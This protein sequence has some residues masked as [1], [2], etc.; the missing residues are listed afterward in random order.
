MMKPRIFAG[1]AHFEMYIYTCNGDE[2]VYGFH[3][4]AAYSLSK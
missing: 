1:G 3:A 4:A 2:Y